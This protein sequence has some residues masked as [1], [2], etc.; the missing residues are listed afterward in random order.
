MPAN[1]NSIPLSNLLIALLLTK[2]CFG[3]PKNGQRVVFELSSRYVPRASGRKCWDDNI[4][5][6]DLSMDHKTVL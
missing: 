4:Y 1:K 3:D 2:T 6:V 5:L